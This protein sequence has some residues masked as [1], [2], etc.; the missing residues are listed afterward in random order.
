MV[1]QISLCASSSPM[2][3]RVTPV[4][5]D[6]SAKE[7]GRPQERMPPP[8]DRG[9][10]AGSWAPL[11]TLVYTAY[12]GAAV[13]YFYVRCAYTLDLGALRWC[14]PAWFLNAVPSCA[15]RCASP[16]QSLASKVQDGIPTGAHTPCQ[17]TVVA[18]RAGMHT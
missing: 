11:G 16:R 4:D 10:E 2:C 1:A 3:C 15:L 8:P 9:D 7:A 12:V 13:A 18:R 5:S 6:L 17:T 14:A